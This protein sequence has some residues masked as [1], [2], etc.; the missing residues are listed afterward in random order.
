MHPPVKMPRTVETEYATPRQ[1]P[2]GT[3]EVKSTPGQGTETKAFMPRRNLLSLVEDFDR[4]LPT[5]PSSKPADTAA[6]L[7]DAHPYSCHQRSQR[8][9]A[10]VAARTENSTGPRRCVNAQ[11]GRPDCLHLGNDHRAA[12]RGSNA[13]PFPQRTSSCS[14]RPGTPCET[15]VRIGT[16]LTS[17]PTLL[18][19]RWPASSKPSVK[20]LSPFAAAPGCSRNDSAASNS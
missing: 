9:L 7:A 16:P 19:A 11:H 18:P 5:W 3:S 15:T 8:G 13:R 14:S 12:R 1:V 10:K 6:T 2:P 17:L 4:S 20:S